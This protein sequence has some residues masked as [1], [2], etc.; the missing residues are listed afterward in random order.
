MTQTFTRPCAQPIC[1][2]DGNDCVN[3]K[4]MMPNVCACHIG[5]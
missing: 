5:W 2:F 4:C 1:N 3:G